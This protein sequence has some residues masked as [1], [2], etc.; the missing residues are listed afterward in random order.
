MF[1]PREASADTISCRDNEY[2]LSG[3]RY[4]SLVLHIGER[5]RNVRRASYSSY[6][7]IQ[8]ILKI[9]NETSTHSSFQ[10]LA[11][12]N[13]DSQYLVPSPRRMSILRVHSLLIYPVCSSLQQ[14]DSYRCSSSRNILLW[15]NR[16]LYALYDV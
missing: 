15:S 4:I 16:L 9:H 13:L 3:Y 12:A 8:S 5:L 6:L 7:S 14:C 11:I 1:Q 10:A 2:V